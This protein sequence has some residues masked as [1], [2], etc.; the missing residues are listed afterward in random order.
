MVIND[1]AYVL[2]FTSEEYKFEDYIE[3]AEKILN[4]LTF[5]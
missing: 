5:I 2:T 4:S 3:I 1:K